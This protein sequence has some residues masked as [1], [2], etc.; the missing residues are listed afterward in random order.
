MSAVDRSGLVQLAVVPV[1]HEGLEPGA[2]AL[3]SVL[4]PLLTD[5]PA[6]SFGSAKLASAGSVEGSVY[7]L[8]ADDY[9]QWVWIYSNAGCSYG[10]IFFYPATKPG[11]AHEAE[12]IIAELEFSPPS[13]ATASADA[14]SYTHLTLPTIHSV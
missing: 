7:Q 11:I 5:T 13:M 14:V 4:F 10:V 9:E 6:A 8:S 3:E 2:E 12:A 1:C